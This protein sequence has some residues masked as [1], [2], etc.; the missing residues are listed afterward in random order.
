MAVPTPHRSGWRRPPARKP[1]AL[2]VKAAMCA[3]LVVMFGASVATPAGADPNSGGDAPNPFGGIS[4]N[5]SRTA[6]TDGPA[7]RQQISEGIHQ[8]LSAHGPST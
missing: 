4:C 2:T 3:A 5:C 6:P 8:G 1:L 7:S